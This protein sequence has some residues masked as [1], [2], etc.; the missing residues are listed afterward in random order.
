MPTVKVIRIIQYEGTVEA[1]RH[2][3]E[4]SLMVGSR[5]CTGYT[6]TIAEHLNELPPLLEVS[7][8]LVQEALVDAKPVGWPDQHIPEESGPFIE[9]LRAREALVPKPVGCCCAPAG[10]EGMWAAGLCP[11]HHGIRR[12]K[13][14]TPYTRSKE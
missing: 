4:K 12:L 14:S 6:L 8:E 7:P 5:K 1:V 9:A 2:A 3:I 11:V 13:I 10:H